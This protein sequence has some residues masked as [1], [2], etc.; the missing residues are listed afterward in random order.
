[1][2]IGVLALQGAVPE[3]VAAVQRA[4]RASGKRGEAILVRRPHDL[5]K[6]SA[7][8]IP[9]GE[10]TTISRLIDKFKLR[11]PIIQ[12]ARAGMPMM[13]TCAGC[14]IVASGGDG[15][16][17]QMKL[18]DAQVVRNAFGRQRE[19]FER[20]LD[21]NGYDSPFCAVFIRAPI[22]EKVWGECKALASVPE[23]IVMAK[24]GNILA[25]AFHPELTGDPRI[26]EM[27]IGMV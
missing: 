19:S 16:I 23:G 27:L 9:G 25:L 6:V 2:R 11:E 5:E 17:E 10:S 12:R 18:I 8:I 4:L 14:I 20:A 26:H 15:T 24:Q 1:M 22:I 13:G 3:H 7:L 21:I